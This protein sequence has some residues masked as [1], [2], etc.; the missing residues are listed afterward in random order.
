MNLPLA[1]SADLNL[2]LHSNVRI[3]EPGCLTAHGMVIVVIRTLVLLIILVV[4]IIVHL[5]LLGN[6]GVVDNLAACTATARDD[7]ALV[8]RL[9]VAV[10]V[11]VLLCKVL[12]LAMIEL[13]S[14]RSKSRSTT[15]PRNDRGLGQLCLRMKGAR[16]G[17]LLEA[18][19]VSTPLSSGK[20]GGGVQYVS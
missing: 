15:R 13:I 10:H 17:L 18:R 12:G 4:I 5:V 3:V 8:D 7:V 2:I 14:G 1:H 11:L 6:I 19:K 9:E 20:Q 16:T